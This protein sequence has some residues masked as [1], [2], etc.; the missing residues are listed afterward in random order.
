[1]TEP[2]TEPMFTRCPSCGCIDWPP[3]PAVHR[4]SCPNINRPASEWEPVR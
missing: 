2:Q 4:P 3:Y 1:M